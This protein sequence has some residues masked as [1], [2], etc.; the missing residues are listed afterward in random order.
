M[1]DPANDPNPGYHLRRIAK[2]TLGEVSK[3]REEVDELADAAEQGVKIMMMVELS[4]LYGAMEA[5]LRA[6]FPG[7]TMDDLAQMSAVTQRAFAHGRR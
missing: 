5:L 2:G 6:Q 4:D 7:M 1:A 3:V